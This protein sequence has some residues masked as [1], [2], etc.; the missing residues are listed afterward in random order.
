MGAF[1][2]T[3]FCRTP[4][5]LALRPRCPVLASFLLLAMA[6]STP[7]AFIPRLIGALIVLLIGLVVGRLVGALVTTA[8]RAIRFD[9]SAARAGIDDFLRNA[10][11]RMA[12][13]G[14]GGAL[15]KWCIYLVS[16]QVAAGA[17][18]FPQPTALIH[19]VRAFLPRLV[20]APVILLA[21]ALVGTLLAGVVRGSRGAARLGD[22]TTLARG[23]RDGVLA[24]AV[25]AA[26]RQLE[27]APAIVSTLWTAL[28]GGRATGQLIKGEIRPGMEVGVDGAG[29]AVARVGAAYTTLRTG[30][31]TCKL[32]D[33][34]LARKT[35]IVAGGGQRQGRQPPP[36]Q[37]APRDD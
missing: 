21:G 31:G 16:F 30:G 28:I 2:A 15:A 4:L 8:L 10:G 34:A 33:A 17:L 1:A 29:G 23:A 3:I 5:P 35:V 7:F 13:A 24:V 26:R 37:A 12:P 9:P 11:G 20:A 14:G 6:L 36:P 18:G 25:V 27:I 32:P 22:A 19:D